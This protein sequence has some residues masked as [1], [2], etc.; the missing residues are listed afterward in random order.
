MALSFTEKKSIRKN[1]GK[2]KEILSIPNLID[3]QK[4]SYE[5]FLSSDDNQSNLKKGYS[6]ISKN[7]KIINQSKS[8]KENDILSATLMDSTIKIK[9]KKIN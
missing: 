2:L 3:V 4:K 9:I 1:F 5:Q 6:I 8:I 7:E